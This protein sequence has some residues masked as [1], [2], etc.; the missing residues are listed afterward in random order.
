MIRVSKGI[1]FA[2]S[3][4]AIVQSFVLI[5]LFMYIMEPMALP[6]RP[7]H[8]I[9]CNLE[10]TKEDWE[11]N[12]NKAIDLELHEKKCQSGCQTEDN[13]DVLL[14]ILVLSHV[15]NFERRKMIR[16]TWL[17]FAELRTVTVLH[18]FLLAKPNPE[19]AIIEQQVIEEQNQFNDVWYFEDVSESYKNLSAKT[20]RGIQKMTATVNFQYL[21]KTV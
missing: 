3:G 20:Y 19:S 9:S 21:F 4:I 15:K 2:I 14:S 18:K 16:D 17:K 7:I 11:R 12:A 13:Q 5:Y 8:E 6:D 1:F 10:A